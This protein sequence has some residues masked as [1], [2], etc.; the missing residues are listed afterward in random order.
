MDAARKRDAAAVAIGF[1]AGV[2][3]TFIIFS[4]IGSPNRYEL[5]ASQDGTIVHKIDTKTGRVWWKNSYEEIDAQ[6]Q[7]VTIWY[8][9]ELSL[10]R[11]GAAKLAKEL[12]VSTSEARKAE[13][14]LLDR[15]AKEREELKKKR[16]DE[17]F[18][19]CGDDADCASKKCAI[20]YK[21][22]K[23]P[24]WSSYCV[25]SLKARISNG[26]IDRCGGNAGCIKSY[27]VNKF[28]NTY[29]AVSDCISEINLQK[30][31]NENTKEESQEEGPQRQ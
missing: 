24:D 13:E 1:A 8:W 27:C 11:P 25:D 3:I 29:P 22:A 14:E 16:L 23:D 4:F 17:I 18:S 7:P 28:N 10:S 15:E 12:K 26:V 9:D 30:V 2:I 19:I 20:G 31:K 21:G 6:G 5:V